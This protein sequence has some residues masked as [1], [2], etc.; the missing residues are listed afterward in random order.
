MLNVYPVISE[1]DKSDEPEIVSANV[2]Y[3]P[4]NSCT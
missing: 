1:L 2:Y 4:L 3:P